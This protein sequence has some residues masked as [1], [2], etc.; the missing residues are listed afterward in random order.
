MPLCTTRVQLEPRGERLV[1]SPSA[2]P[3]L[4][5][6]GPPG[7]HTT[8]AGAHVL[9]WS[10]DEVSE[11]WHFGDWLGWLTKAGVLPPM[12]GTGA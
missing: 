10:G 12:P 4:R 7:K 3:G 6:G 1:P 2:G 9:H 5:P 11:A 8:A